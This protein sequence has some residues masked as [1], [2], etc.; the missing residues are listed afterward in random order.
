[1]ANETSNGTS[2][3][4]SVRVTLRYIRVIASELEYKPMNSEL[5]RMQF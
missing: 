5:F 3:A 2:S 4:H 1:M